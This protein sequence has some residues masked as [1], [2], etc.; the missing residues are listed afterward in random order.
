MKFLSGLKSFR[1]RALSSAPN[2]VHLSF[3][4][5]KSHHDNVPNY[6]DYID[7]GGN[8]QT[9]VYISKRTKARHLHKIRNFVVLIKIY[10]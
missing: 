3:R 5:A 2:N 6:I 1:I 7:S 10:Y 4:L 9:K 8:G